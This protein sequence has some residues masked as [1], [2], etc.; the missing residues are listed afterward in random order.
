MEWEDI[1]EE[2]LEIDFSKINA[3]KRVRKDETPEVLRG[4]LDKLG[5]GLEFVDERVSKG[6]KY[7][8]IQSDIDNP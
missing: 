2:V 5:R 8:R 3:V 6:E 4:F 7:L 1:G